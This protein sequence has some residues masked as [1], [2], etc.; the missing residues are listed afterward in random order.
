MQLGKLLEE[1]Y[2]A[3]GL[4][5][6]RRAA[7]GGSTT[8]VI[9]TGLANKYGENKFSQGIQG[10]HILFIAQTTDRAAPEGQY[11]EVSAYATPTSTPTFTVPTMSAAA[12]SGDIYAVMKPTIQLYEMIN[13]V[14]EGL[15]RLPKREKTDTSL[16]GT[17]DTLSYSLPLPINRYNIQKI[18]IGNNT[19]G[20]QDAPGFTIVPA[21]GSTTDKLLFTKQPPYDTTTAANQTFKITYRDVHP[22]LSTYS[23]Y[24][25]KNI[26]DELALAVCVESALEYLMNKKPSFFQDKNKLAVYQNAMKRAADAREMHMVRTVPARRQNSLNFGDM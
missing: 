1:C 11:G 5:V 19:D 24:V 22:V 16:T 23:D 15:R 17:I 4:Q 13:R 21:T 25:E 18:E 2:V 7:T 8:T 10:G 14:N 20:W 9:D 6:L 26:P 12:G 3:C